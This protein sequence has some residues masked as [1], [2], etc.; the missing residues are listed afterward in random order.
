MK[1]MKSIA[2]CPLGAAQ[3]GFAQTSD[4]LQTKAHLGDGEVSFAEIC[5]AV[6]C[7]ARGTLCSIKAHT[8]YSTALT[9]SNSDCQT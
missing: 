5:S 3:A 9:L 2:N 6:T 1:K 7:V 8:G 4:L